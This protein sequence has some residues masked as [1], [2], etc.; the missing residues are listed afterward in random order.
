MILPRCCRPSRLRAVARLLKKA[1]YKL[2]RE[3]DIGRMLKSIRDS[4]SVVGSLQTSKVFDRDTL[5]HEY[6]YHYSNVLDLNLDTEMSIEE[7]MQPPIAITYKDPKPECVCP[8]LGQGNIIKIAETAYGILKSEK[9]LTIRMEESIK[10]KRKLK[11]EE[12]KS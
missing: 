7:E 11:A 9:E 5:L 1:E 10:K 3:M 6:Q 2:H 8:D 4:R 12:T